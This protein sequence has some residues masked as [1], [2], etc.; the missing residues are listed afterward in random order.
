RL[1]GLIPCGAAAAPRCRA[2]S[3]DRPA[4]ALTDRSAV[5]TAPELSCRGRL[6][7]SST[8]MARRPLGR[9]ALLLLRRDEGICRRQPVR[10][11]DAR[12]DRARRSVPA[13]P[14]VGGALL[15]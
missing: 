11:W 13:R 1:R 14:R 15:R 7:V 3:T 2:I 5:G 12:H 8:P 6:A 9:A 10:P 4:V